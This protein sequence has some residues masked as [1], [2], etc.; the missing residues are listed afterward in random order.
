MEEAFEFFNVFLEGSAF[1]AGDKLT[2]ADISL[3]ATVSS[4]EAASF[5]FSKYANVARWYAST[6]ASCPGVAINDAGVAEFKKFFA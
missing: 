1:A 2:V 6:K 4:Y 3:Y 5:D